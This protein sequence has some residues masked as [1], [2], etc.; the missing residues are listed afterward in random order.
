MPT[1]FLKK[2]AAVSL[3]IAAVVASGD[4][5]ACTIFTVSKGNA[6]YFAGN[7]DQSAN[8][9]YWVVDRSGKYGVVFIATP[10]DD[11]PLVMQMGVNE[12]GLSYDINAIGRESLVPQ[13]GKIRQTEWALVRLMRE[14]ATVQEMLD[15]I[16]AYD[17]GSSIAYQIHIADRSGDA[18][19]IHPGKDGRLTFTRIDRRQGYLISTNFNVRDTGTMK[20]VSRRYLVTEARL[21][22]VEGQA[23]L[24]PDAV[25]LVL[26]AT[27]QTGGVISP[28]RTIYSTVVD[29]KALTL[30]VYYEGDFRK[31][32]LFDLRSELTGGH[33]TTMVPLADRIAA[34]KGH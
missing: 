19:V 17:W 20:F 4:A 34:L 32:Y 26:D 5:T 1:A 25:A 8:H 3:A 2:I 23:A 24:S 27:H 14:T 6:V 15:K 12:K 9:A 28:V 33:G 18:A 11:L 30:R 21:R 16:F 31:P 10:T 29:L 13:P 7:E 22:D